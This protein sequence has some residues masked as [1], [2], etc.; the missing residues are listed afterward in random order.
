[1]ASGIRTI[2]LKYL[3]K[4]Y[5]KVIPMRRLVIEVLYF[6]RN[7]A[8]GAQEFLFNLLDYFYER[9]EDISYDRI[10]IACRDT[11]QDAFERYKGRLETFG[12]KHNNGYLARFMAVARLPKMLNMGNDDLLFSP[13]NHSGLI[14]KGPQVL[15]IHDL[16]FRHEDLMH[17]RAF[18]MQRQ[19]YVPRSIRLANKVIAIS[20]ATAKEIEDSYDFANGKVVTVYN[21]MNFNKYDRFGRGVDGGYFLVVSA[22]YYHKNIETIIK[23]FN[24]YVDDGGT[25]SLYYVGSIQPDSELARTIESCTT[26]ARERIK[27]ISHISNK[28]LGELYN[29]ASAFISA[30]LYEGFGMPIAEA[31]SFNLPVLL[32]DTDIHR[33][34][35]LD[36]AEYFSPLDYRY[37]AKLM[38][39]VGS[40]RKTY[41]N[42]I[43]EKYSET[44][45]SRHYVEIINEMYEN[46]RRG[47]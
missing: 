26:S 34:I 4:F 33:E 29:N 38:Q 15:V 25:R 17:N 3:K 40:D 44:N 39:N 32:A 36:L 12:V 45:T 21:Y 43:I 46:T 10:I 47:G 2:K 27:V 8:Y 28:E 9:R 23:A 14:Y 19:L 6:E 5:Y 7:K 18:R 30:S 16:L 31:M 22:S 11:Q 35:S 24:Q 42:T 41:A 37:L 1:M 20:K 13:G